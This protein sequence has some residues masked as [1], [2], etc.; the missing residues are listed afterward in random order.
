MIT[1]TMSTMGQT[2]AQTIR[3]LRRELGAIHLVARRHRYR[4]IQLNERIAEFVPSFD[5]TTY[6][7]RRSGEHPTAF[8]SFDSLDK[9]EIIERLAAAEVQTAA[10]SVGMRRNPD[11]RAS[12]LDLKLHRHLMNDLNFMELAQSVRENALHESERIPGLDSLTGSLSLWHTLTFVTSGESVVGASQGALET[13]LNFNGCFGDEMTQVH[14]PESFLP[15]ALLGARCWQRYGSLPAVDGEHLGA[16]RLM[17]HPRT[18]ESVLRAVGL[19]ELRLRLR[20]DNLNIRC[21]GLFLADD[22]T[23]EGLWTARDFDDLGHATFRQPLIV[24]GQN[25]RRT[26]HPNGFGQSWFPHRR[27]PE[28][29]ATPEVSFSGL[30]VGRGESTVQELLATAGRTLL[31]TDWHVRADKAL[32]LGFSANNIRGIVMEGDNA[33]GLLKP[34]GSAIS[35][36]LFDGDRSLFGGG[37]LSRELQDTGS[38]VTPFLMSPMTV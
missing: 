36:C 1:E 38:A 34:G 11:A 29:N 9:D 4:K 16:L 25:S 6:L 33:I 22:P 19:N 3:E 23:I 14:A 15:I 31:V 18:L 10:V 13:K 35:G 30:L 12:G 17:L 37:V 27:L 21:D 24:R 26:I 8:L 2:I 28:D 32:P 20:G 7:L 5:T